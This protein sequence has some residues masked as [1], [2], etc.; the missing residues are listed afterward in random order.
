VAGSFVGP[1]TATGTYQWTSGSGRFSHPIGNALFVV[2]SLDGV[3]FTVQF[4]GSLAS[5][6]PAP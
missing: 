3:S 2:T 1:G 4:K 5:A 6:Q